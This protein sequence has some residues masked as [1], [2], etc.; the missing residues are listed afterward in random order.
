MI[1]EPAD[2]VLSSP[3]W[4]VLQITKGCWVVLPKSQLVAGLKLG[5]AWRR[6]AAMKARLGDRD[7]D[8]MADCPWPPRD[9]RRTR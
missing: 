3:D 5:R 4:V 6:A 1:V 2:I 8:A 9:N 7:R